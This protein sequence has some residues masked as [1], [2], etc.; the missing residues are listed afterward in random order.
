MSFGKENIIQRYSFKVRDEDGYLHKLYLPLFQWATSDNV[1][2]AM[3]EVM[4]EFCRKTDRPLPR[5]TSAL[6]V[7]IHYDESGLEVV[8]QEVNPYYDVLSLFKK[9]Y[10]RSNDSWFA[11]VTHILMNR[12]EEP[13]EVEPELEPV[14][15]FCDAIKPTYINGDESRLLD[16]VNMGGYFSNS[17]VQ[18]HEFSVDKLMNINFYFQ[19]LAGNTIDFATPVAIHLIVK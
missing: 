7:R 12:E 1:T 11:Y 3:F 4:S 9:R 16:I 10:D 18:F 17:I 5:L 6:F 15:L 2:R 19:S 8:Q 13:E 14:L